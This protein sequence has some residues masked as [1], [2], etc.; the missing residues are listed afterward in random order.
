MSFSP[1]NTWFNLKRSREIS[2]FNAQGT[3]T[4]KRISEGN[5]SLKSLGQ[6]LQDAFKSKGVRVEM[7]TPKGV[8]KIHSPQNKHILLDH[9]FFTRMLIFKNRYL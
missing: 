6:D 5:Y 1:Y 8:P 2:V 7:N 9:V 3:A 4:V